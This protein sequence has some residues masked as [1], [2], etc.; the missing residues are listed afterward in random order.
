MDD[1]LDI[2]H[3]HTSF[4]TP[5]GEVRA[6]RDVSFSLRRGEVLG[7]VGESGSGKSVTMLSILRLLGTS[8]RVVEGSIRFDGTEL[9]GA[10]DETVVTLRGNRIGMIFQ[11]PM[12]CLNPVLSVGYQ[13]MEPLI[14]HRGMTK[15]QA[16]ER[17]IAML[18]QVGIDPAEKRID[19]YPHQFSGGQRQRIMIAMALTC[20]PALLIADE[21]TTALDVTIQAQ[22][23]E[24]MKALQARTGTSIILITHDLGV[25]AGMA[26]RVVVMYGGRIVERGARRDIF[27]A[28]GHPYTKGL[29]HSVP[30]PDTLVRERLIPIE[31]QPPDL[32]SPPPGCPFAARCPET[33]RVCMTMPPEPTE[34][35][36]GHITTCWLHARP[37]A[38]KTHGGAAS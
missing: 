14:R 6:V 33:M 9:A 22:I 5:V 36:E 20:D 29:L 19:Q 30:N 13:L 28:P 2:R 23:L 11:D 25:V 15:A 7:I 24:L 26:D 32:L 35:S 10:D 27:Y 18:R 8:G 3:L 38:A 4:F 12:T 17:A 37:G 21:P 34:L 31:G 1:L 16:R